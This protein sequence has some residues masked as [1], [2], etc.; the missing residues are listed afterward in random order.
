MT[1]GYWLW[2][3]S[4]GVFLGTLPLGVLVGSLWYKGWSQEQA[5]RRK[6]LKHLS[7]TAKPAPVKPLRRKP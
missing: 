3:I 7:E 1:D 2:T 5:E 4:K 6:W